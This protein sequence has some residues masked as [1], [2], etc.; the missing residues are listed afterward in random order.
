MISGFDSLFAA[1]YAA[2]RAS[3]LGLDASE[4]TAEAIRYT[5]RYGNACAF[6]PTI[7]YADSSGDPSLDQAASRCYS[8]WMHCPYSY[9]ETCLPRP[10]LLHRGRSFFGVC[11]EVSR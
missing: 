3:G 4:E 10:Y 5:H 6:L 1:A 11:P 7:T 8:G 9:R 2:A